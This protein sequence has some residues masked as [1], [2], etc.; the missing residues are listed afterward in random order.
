MIVGLTNLSIYKKL[1]YFCPFLMDNISVTIKN[2]FF[3]FIFIFVLF[4]FSF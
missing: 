2:F 1:G 4:I 3:P